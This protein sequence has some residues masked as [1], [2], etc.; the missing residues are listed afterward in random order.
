MTA[1]IPQHVREEQLNSLPGKRFVRWLDGYRNKS[2]RAVMRCDKGHEW[3]ARVFH[4]VDNNCG[5]PVC[6]GNMTQSRVDVEDKLNRIDGVHFVRWRD[7]AYKNSKSVAIMLCDNS[8]EWSARAD[9]VS[10]SA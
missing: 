2:S 6:A 4:L 1:R 3:S 8:H 9:S 5:C 7:G 10:A